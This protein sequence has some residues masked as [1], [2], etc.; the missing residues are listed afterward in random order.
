MSKT[1]GPYLASD[2]RDISTYQCVQLGRD[3]ETKQIKVYSKQEWRHQKNTNPH[4]NQPK[5]LVS[6]PGACQSESER[7]TKLGRFTEE[8]STLVTAN[9]T[10]GGNRD[11]RLRNNNCKSGSDGQRYPYPAGVVCDWDWWWV[12]GKGPKRVE[13][14][15][16]HTCEKF[17]PPGSKGGWLN[18]TENGRNW[19]KLAKFSRISQK[20]AVF[21]KNC[22]VWPNLEEETIPHIMCVKA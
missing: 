2:P 12:Q 22:W 5:A 21:G 16:F 6:S 1:V 20:L 18:F 15:C 19:Q 13:D 17:S 11:E 7:R 8:I 3:S 14:I 4:M 10:N 9:V